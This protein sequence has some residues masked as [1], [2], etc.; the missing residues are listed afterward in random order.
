M[1]DTYQDTSEILANQASV[2]LARYKALTADAMEFPYTGQTG[3]ITYAMWTEVTE[4]GNT[5]PDIT[6]MDEATDGGYSRA[7]SLFSGPNARVNRDFT[8]VVN[9]L[10]RGMRSDLD[11][12]IELDRFGQPYIA[13]HMA[14]CRQAVSI[15]VEQLDRVDPNT[16]VAPWHS[17]EPAE[18]KSGNLTYEVDGELWSIRPY[19]MLSTWDQ[20]KVLVNLCANGYEN[21]IRSCL[22]GKIEAEQAAQL[23]EKQAVILYDRMA[24]GFMV[25]YSKACDVVDKKLTE[26]L[27]TQAEYTITYEPPKGEW[28][29]SMKIVLPPDELREWKEAGGT[30]VQLKRLRGVVYTMLVNEQTPQWWKRYQVTITMGQIA[31]ALWNDKNHHVTEKEYDL[32]AKS[33]ALLVNT[34]VTSEYPPKDS[35]RGHEHISDEHLRITGSRLFPAQFVSGVDAMGHVVGDHGALRFYD[36]PPLDIQADTLNQTYTIPYLNGTPKLPKRRG[37]RISR[38][39]YDTVTELGKY[40][41]MAKQYGSQTAYIDTIAHDLEPFLYDEISREIEGC[42]FRGDVEGRKRAQRRMSNLRAGVK[43]DVIKLLPE[44]V[45]NERTAEKP[46]FFSVYTAKGK[47]DGF[48]ITRV[49]QT[50]EQRREHQQPHTTFS[51][52]KSASRRRAGKANSA[53]PGSRG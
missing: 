4:A 3:T 44:L 1:T 14:G 24:S 27:T 36:L 29:P 53:R 2:N 52:G 48:T 15:P 9:A 22:G 42:D 30:P 5:D 19:E 40:M 7:V 45:E 16:I 17:K 13:Q 37:R 41:R 33:L 49:K 6:S 32:L 11:E 10:G 50:D 8:R 18:A 34:N 28:A 31:R 51:Y 26:A 25:G 35:R 39:D 21:A 23:E 47:N 38:T 43:R 12:T 20:Y 46:C